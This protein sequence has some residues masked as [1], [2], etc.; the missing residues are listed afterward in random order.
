[1]SEF[2]LVFG[3][4]LV[5]FGVRYPVL[6]LISRLELP[7]LLKRSL[8]YVP[9]AV[10]S[11]IIAPSVLISEND[12]LIISLENPALVGSVVAGLVAWRWKNLLFTILTGMAAFWITRL[13][14]GG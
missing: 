13:L 10:L 3:M 5:T 1:M 7:N 8:K 6:A 2:T 9:P 14:L 12:A 11:A 4:M